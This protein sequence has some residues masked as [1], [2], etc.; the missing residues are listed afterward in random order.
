MER[1][2]FLKGIGLAGMASLI[3]FGKALACTVVPTETSGPYPILSGQ[4]AATLR[5]DIR[6]SEAGQL[7]KIKLKILGSTNCEPIANAEVDIWH[8]NAY[9]NYSGYTT[10]GHSGTTNSA[11]QTW[12]RGRAMTDANGEVEFTTIFP[13]WYSGRLCHVHFEVKING[14]SV[15]ISQFTYPTTE[16]NTI[17]TTIAPYSTWGADPAVA[18]TDNVF[19]D[20]TT[21]QVATLVYNSTTLSWDSYLEATVPGTGTVGIKNIDKITGG[22][23]D[24][25][26]NFP[27]PFSG[28]TT[29]PFTLT[30]DADVTFG[31]F[32]L[33]GKK[34]AEVKQTKL[35]AGDHT[36]DINLST[37]HLPVANYL[38]EITV[39]NK[40]GTYHQCKMMTA[41]K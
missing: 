16:K 6:E 3:P 41:A 13:G 2:D 36:V 12:L 27:N 22:Q 18:T 37:L 5:T 4:L 23:F 39:S 1:K 33:Q 7:H 35:S 29:I 19:S 15:K 9:G 21:G 40:I 10:N 34:V 14:T 11:G 25:G 24:L 8:C 38:Y 26:Q 28:I 30:N 32:N 31:I 17:H 20:G